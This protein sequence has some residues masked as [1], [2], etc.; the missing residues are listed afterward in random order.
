MIGR[1]AVSALSTADFEA[2]Q[3]DIAADKTA[4][5]PKAGKRKG[6]RQRGGMAAGG[7]GAASRTL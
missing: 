3:A 7:G 2:M 1:R 6:K 5:K 4:V